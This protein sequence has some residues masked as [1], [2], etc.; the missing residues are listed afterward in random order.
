MGGI[1]YVSFLRRHV[2]DD[3]K[4][5]SL[6]LMTAFLALCMVVWLMVLGGCVR[7]GQS[8]DQGT[9]TDGGSAADA[10]V[11]AEP[12]GAQIMSISFVVD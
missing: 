10:S 11:D 2:V 1:R 5:T 12:D 7:H 9:M 6:L 4:E 3:F 8:Y